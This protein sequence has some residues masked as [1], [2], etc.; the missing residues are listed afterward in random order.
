MMRFF[1]SGDELLNLAAIVRVRRE[2]TVSRKAQQVFTAK[3]Q[4]APQPVSEPIS[5]VRYRIKLLTGDE[6]VFNRE[7]G[8]R[9][10]ALLEKFL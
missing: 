3:G 2:Q 4:Y 6:I 7:E 5:S 9:L 8:E 1:N 10:S